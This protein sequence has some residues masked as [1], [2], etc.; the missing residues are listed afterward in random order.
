MTFMIRGRLFIDGSLV[1]PEMRAIGASH[2]P[3]GGSAGTHDVG[4]A[5]GAADFH[6][7]TSRNDDFPVSSQ[8]VQ[9][10]KNG[11]GVV[12]HHQCSLGSREFTQDRLGMD[13]AGTTPS[14]IEIVFEVVVSPAQ[15]DQPFHRFFGKE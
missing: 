7:L 12:V 6:Q 9:Y 1:I 14:S 2:I 15:G 13:I 8:G 4:N 5:K 10:E 11:P 3:Q